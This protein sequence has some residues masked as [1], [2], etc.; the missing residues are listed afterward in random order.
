[1]GVHDAQIWTYDTLVA[2][3]FGIPAVGMAGEA[4]LRGEWRR[5]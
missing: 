1:M 4:R 5:E 2:G 3:E